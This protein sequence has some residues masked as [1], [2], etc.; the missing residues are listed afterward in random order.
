ML[1]KFASQLKTK[2]TPT[3]EHILVE[4]VDGR[5]VLVKEE[6]CERRLGIYENEFLINLKP[7]TTR[8]FDVIIGMDCLSPNNAKIMCSQQVVIVEAP[9]RSLLVIRGERKGK[10]VS[11]ISMEKA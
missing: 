7:I 2:L 5:Y 11:I 4:V 6:Y 8:E 3:S 10:E 1:V 9:D